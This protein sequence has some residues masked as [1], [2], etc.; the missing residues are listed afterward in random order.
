MDITQPPLQLYDLCLPE[1]PERSSLYHLDPM[2]VST[3]LVE[4][5]TSYLIRLSY[6]HCVVPGV[7]ISTRITP[8]IN[9]DAPLCDHR[10]NI[11]A[12]W[13]G[14]NANTSMCNGMQHTAAKVCKVLKQLTRRDDLHL[15]TMLPWTEVISTMRLLR[16]K[17]TWCPM[18]Y[19]YWRVINQVL[20]DPLIWSLK[21]ITMCPYHRQSLLQRCPHCSQT[22][23]LL[24]S[25]SLPAGYC[26][27]CGKWLG[28]ISV[29]Q[30]FVEALSEDELKWQCWVFDNVGELITKTPDLSSIHK[31]RIK[32]VVSAY[33]KY[34]C[35]GNI[36]AFCRLTQQPDSTVHNWYSGKSVPQLAQLLQVCYSLQISLWNFLTQPI[37]DISFNSLSSILAKP[38]QLPQSKPRKRL[39]VV[40]AEAFLQTALNEFPP[41]PY[42]EVV[43][44]LDT[45]RSSLRQR[46]PDLS[47]AISSRY[48][49]YQKEQQFEL[50]RHQLET[51]IETEQPPPSLRKVAIQLK[52]STVRLRSYCPNLCRTIS[53]RHATYCRIMA[54]QAKEDIQEQVR[55]IALALYSRGVNPTSGKVSQQMLH[56]AVFKKMAAQEALNKVRSELNY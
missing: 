27:K 54:E 28:K 10:A 41:P 4:S 32:L 36:N 44:R 29:A 45:N 48:A 52:T 18:C 55:Q 40:K 12:I 13:G 38:S 22:S 49:N 5:L 51:I 24:T 35:S 30:D 16:H 3:P 7:L 26:S 34:V 42:Q 56:P 33:V 53:E 14:D 8:A 19:E 1:I 17:R 11:R 43:E 21:V 47:R 37:E 9:P 50:I 39:N 2:S 31:T 15:L 46:F 6:E 23:R 20:Y 25:H